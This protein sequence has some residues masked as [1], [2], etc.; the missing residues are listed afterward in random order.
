MVALKKNLSPG[1]VK[2]WRRCKYF[3]LQK[4]ALQLLENG[5]PVAARSKFC[6]QLEILHHCTPWYNIAC[7]E[8]LLG[9]TSAA[10]RS[11]QKSIEAGYNDASHLE[12]DDNLNALRNIPEFKSMISTLRSTVNNTSIPVISD[13]SRFSITEPALKQ[14]VASTAPPVPVCVNVPTPELKLSVPTV[15]QPQPASSVPNPNGQDD[16]MATLF[17]MGFTDE[18]KNAEALKEAKGNIAAAVQNLIEEKSMFS[19][20]FNMKL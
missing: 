6:E 16:P 14:T 10:L 7:C 5:D 2:R 1:E 17:H 20:L 3:H 13:K 8:A 12:T 4:K 9:D 19:K 15:V 11:L 18:I